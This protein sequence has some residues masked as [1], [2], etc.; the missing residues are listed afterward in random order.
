M[1]IAL[2]ARM[3]VDFI[4]NTEI[5]STGIGHRSRNDKIFSDEFVSTSR[6]HRSHYDKRRQKNVE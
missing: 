4:G 3:A 6:D 5:A 2:L 1:I